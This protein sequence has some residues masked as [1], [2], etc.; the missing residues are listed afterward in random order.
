MTLQ[1]LWIT[2]AGF[3]RSRVG[4]GAEASSVARELRVRSGVPR[5]EH[6]RPVPRERVILESGRAIRKLGKLRLHHV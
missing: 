3:E 2:F 5:H 1:R 6:S 4:E